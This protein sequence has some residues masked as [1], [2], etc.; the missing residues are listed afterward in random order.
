MSDI[1]M[2]CHST[3]WPLGG[4]RAWVVCL[5]AGLFFLYE[6]LQLTVFDVINPALRADFSINPLQLSWLSSAY[7]WA[8]IAFLIPAG[9]L[10]DRFCARMVVLSALLL[11]V[12]GTLGFALTHLYYWAFFFHALAGVGNAFCFLACVVFVSRWFPANRQTLVIGCITT[13]AFAG[14]VLAH[15]PMAYLTAKFGWRH[16]LGVDVALG[17]LILIWLGKVLHDR[18]RQP[19]Q[20]ARALLTWRDWI[21]LASHRQIVLP[22]LYTACLNLPIMVLCALWGASYLTQVQQLSSLEASN[23]VSLLFFGSMLGCPLVGWLSDYTA[24]PRGVMVLGSLVTLLVWM[25]FFTLSTLPIVAL[26]GLFFLLG[27]FT[28]T[29]VISYPLIASSQTA[30]YTGIATAIA[31]IIIMG[32]AAFAQIL[33]G[34]LLQWHRMHQLFAVT[35][36]TFALGL[37]PVTTVIALL[38]IILTGRNHGND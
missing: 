13:M 19:R 3:D 35:N 37:F 34:S 4:F 5:S 11:C 20:P 24:S 23:V 16:A 30:Q 25:P 31:S 14:G 26:S 12:L 6:F 28:S 7:L 2:Q 29:Q 22:G 27:F 21:R 17:V 32:S 38:A 1:S 15:T 18:P 36:Y 9:L 33:F 8:N 10:L